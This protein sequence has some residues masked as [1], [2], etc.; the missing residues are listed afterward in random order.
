MR[1]LKFILSKGGKRMAAEQYLIQQLIRRVYASIPDLPNEDYKW[2]EEFRGELTN[3]EFY[4]G[5][6]DFHYLVKIILTD[7][8]NNPLSWGMRCY[9][10][11]KFEC[12][13]P[14]IPQEKQTDIDL[15]RIGETI[16]AFGKFGIVVNKSLQICDA[17]LKSQKILKSKII[18]EKLHD[19]G[20]IISNSDNEL[21]VEYPDNPFV[22]QIIKAYSMLNIDNKDSIRNN[23]LKAEWLHFGNSRGN[24]THIDDYCRS[25]IKE[26][27][28]N[29]RGIYDLM[30]KYGYEVTIGS[31]T[32]EPNHKKD[33]RRLC[34]IKKE[35]DDIAYRFRF[36]NLQNY[37]D[38][39]DALPEHIKSEIFNG[40]TQ[41]GSCCGKKNCAGPIKYSRNGIIYG[42]CRLSGE[43]GC[44]V[45]LRKTD[46]ETVLRLLEY[47]LKERSIIYNHS[48]V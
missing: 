35:R 8:K 7:A 43:G 39:C 33:P 4:R 5:F 23:I 22:L 17:K 16:F 2:R 37:M 15:L 26:Q 20:F 9:E 10:S 32:F 6:C 28:D 45:N 48:A 3:Y 21:I 25:M 29:V 19:Y 27:A 1:N 13:A 31:L 11:V 42:K 41:M 14:R 30:I 46:G 40:Y 34:I 38:I 36:D 12:N 47:E 44:F 18:I 24:R